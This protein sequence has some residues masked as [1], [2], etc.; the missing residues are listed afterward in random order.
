MASRQYLEYLGTVW[1]SLS[2]DDKQRMGETWEAYEQIA[3]SIAQKYLED[4]LNL[5]LQD[6]QEN[7]TE[8]WLPYAFNSTNFLS[9]QATILSTQEISSGVNL[10]EKRRLRFTIDGASTFEVDVQ[11]KDPFRSTIQEVLDTLNLA[12]AQL[13]QGSGV[14]FAAGEFEN[15]V[16]RLTSPTSGVNSSIELLPTLNPLLNA[17]DILLGI[18]TT[19]L[20]KVFPE[21]RYAFT[22]PYKTIRSVPLL[23][24]AVR[25]E[26]ITISLVEG[27]D[28][29]VEDGG[30]LNFSE[31]PPVALWARRTMMDEE[32][33]WNN[34]GYF[35]DIYQKNSGQYVGVLQGLW[36]AFWNGPRPINVKR[37][38]YLLF[39]L[40]TAPGPGTISALSS[41]LVELTL[42]AGTVVYYTVPGGLE[43]LQVVGERVEKFDPLVTGIEVFD[44]VNY[45]G[46][47]ESEVGITGIK[48]FM[49]DEAS[50]DDTT[51]AMRMLEEHTFLP[52]ISVNAFVNQSINLKNVKTFLNT[53]KPKASAYLFQIILGAFKDLLAARDRIAYE[54][55][56]DLTPSLDLN[57]TTWQKPSTLLLYETVDNP[58]LGMDLDGVAPGDRLEI[59]VRSN[60]ELIDSFGV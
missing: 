57:E 22:G 39:G 5:T 38:L 16:I 3:A 36:Y 46:F 14:V 9:R 28:Y 29:V 24:D 7:T 15:T 49:L 18:Y 6:L 4:E 34:F 33:P 37:S 31:L 59:E 35:M 26:S 58:S 54:P 43:P 21:F 17:S 11:G 20:P 56:I 53:V 42:D 47:I 8:R 25:D 13:Y 40:P 52:Q 30:I 44:K 1:D 32:T 12:T 50:L 45:P 41:N 27:I 51:K 55:D 19:D 10:S 48:R 23:Q 2:D 60:G